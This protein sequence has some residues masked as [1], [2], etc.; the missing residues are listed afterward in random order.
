MK[1]KQT[2][3]VIHS[4]FVSLKESLSHQPYLA[5][6]SSISYNNKK[7][8]VQSASLTFLG[9]HSSLVVKE[10]LESSH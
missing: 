4:A 2:R 3:K 7:S 9:S 10:G 6:L 8:Q 1:L 5:N